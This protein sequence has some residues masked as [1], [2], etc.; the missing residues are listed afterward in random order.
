MP[1]PISTHVVELCSLCHCPP[2][3]IWLA[4]VAARRDAPV[5]LWLPAEVIDDPT[6]AGRLA[7]AKEADVLVHRVDMP[8]VEWSAAGRRDAVSW[9]ADWAAPRPGDRVLIPTIDYFLMA[10]GRIPLPEGTRLDVVFHQSKFQHRPIPPLHDLLRGRLGLRSRQL[11]R[12]E[13]QRLR[14]IAP[15]RVL[16]LDA[17]AALGPGRRRLVRLVGTDQVEFLPSDINDGTPTPRG[18]ARAWLGIGDTE[19]LLVVNGMLGPWK[20]IKTLIAAWPQVCSRVPGARLALVGEVPG[21]A[22]DWSAMLGDGMLLRD[23]IVPDELFLGLVRDA[24]AVWAVRTTPGGMSTVQFDAF[25]A[26]VPCLVSE[27]H[28]PTAW[29]AKRLGGVTI[30]PRRVN[31]VAQGVASAISSSG[32]VRQRDLGILADVDLAGDVILARRRIALGDLP[33]QPQ[34]T[35]S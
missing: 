1:R 27:Q 3:A 34:R 12:L 33:D 28:A 2:V 24:D 29:L 18:I 26:G 21:L 13:M 25:K 22:P 7:R 17:H 35:A 19:P 10:D 4:T 31:S 6:H 11:G 9:L 15:H 32:E 8:P 20:D 23:E 30:T 5:E 14:A 16:F